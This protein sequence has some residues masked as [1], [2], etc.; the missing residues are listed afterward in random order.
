MSSYNGYDTDAY[1]NWSPTD[2]HSGSGSGS[3]GLSRR[4]STFSMLSVA[5]ALPLYSEDDHYP[6]PL[7]LPEYTH[8]RAPSPTYTIPSARTYPPS[9]TAL[10]SEISSC[11]A[12]VSELSLS[13]ASTSTWT[14][15]G[16]SSRSGSSGRTSSRRA[17]PS[18]AGSSSSSG[19]RGPAAVYNP[20]T[21]IF[22]R[23]PTTDHAFH[24]RPE[25]GPGDPWAT[26]ILSSNAESPDKTPR[27]YAG[28][29]IRG[30]VHF[31]LAEPMTIRMITATLRGTI[32]QQRLQS[33][34]SHNFLDDT[35]AIWS[36]D[37]A[38]GDSRVPLSSSGTL[39]GLLAIPFE[40]QFPTDMDLKGDN[41]VTTTVPL[42]E[43]ML[44]QNSPIQLEYK[45]ILTIHRGRFQ[46]PFK[47]PADVIYTPRVTPGPPTPARQLAYH[48]HRAIPGPISDPKGWLITAP[49]QCPG[50]LRGIEDVMISGTVFLPSPASYTRGTA[51]PCK[52]HMNT[53]TTRNIN[54]KEL[55]TM[56][57]CRRITYLDPKVG[58][59]KRL[60]DCTEKVKVDIC[61]VVWF[62][63]RPKGRA[64]TLE[65]ELHIH[66]QLPASGNFPLFTVEYYVVLMAFESDEFTPL[67]TKPLMKRKIEVATE[68]P[69]GPM[70]PRPVTTEP[71]AK[72][73]K[74]SYDSMTLQT[75]F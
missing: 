32:V 71:P 73:L 68:L 31:N 47:I 53:T 48:N 11:A 42:P 40:M 60:K 66:H 20:S 45:V 22:H 27:F 3:S 49:M 65:G 2:S 63:S 15:R 44:E 18:T 7:Q 34:H 35:V 17:R 12:S 43:S 16:S 57:L 46:S 56:R 69:A 41:N 70:P 72:W 6:S 19:E 5:T 39:V 74:T 28:N 75:Y 4:L 29:K 33:N 50:N 8:P 24:L 51:V 52:I 23:T 10:V 38:A 54:V 37:S 61:S 64:V 36:K 55:V 14:S 25:K 9:S 26:L 59:K 30:A 58:R 1:E 62:A 13:A 67:A 21:S